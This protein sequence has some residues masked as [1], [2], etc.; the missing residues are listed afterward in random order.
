[1]QDAQQWISG[2]YARFPQASAFIKRC[3]QAPALRQTIVTPFGRKRRYY[4]ASNENLNDLQNEAANF[5]EQSSAHDITLLTGITVYK[6]LMEKGVKI[7]NEV[8][9]CLLFELKNDLQLIIDTSRFVVSTFERI[10]LEWGLT[11]VPFKAEVEISLA[12]GTSEKIHLENYPTDTT[13]LA[14]QSYEFS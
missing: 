11:G 3:R 12:W 5:P 9:D 4:V 7:V 10:P 13:Q 1:M 14:G 6:P 8:H 2:W